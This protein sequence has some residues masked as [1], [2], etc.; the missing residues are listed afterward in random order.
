MEGLECVDLPVEAGAERKQ[1]L[2]VKHL[3]DNLSMACIKSLFGQFGASDV[4]RGRQSYFVEFKDD[5]AASFAQK[6]LHRVRLL[7]KLLAVE[8]VKQ[9]QGNATTP[10]PARGGGGD[11]TGP[12]LRPTGGQ[13]APADAP[14]QPPLAGTPGASGASLA[15][16]VPPPAVGALPQ[17]QSLQSNG[18]RQ[19]YSTGVVK[20]RGEAIAPSLG[21]DYP[22][23]PHLQYSYPPPDGNILAN[24]MNALIAVPR[25]YTQV[26]PSASQQP[27]SSQ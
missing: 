25:L 12:V 11:Q 20:P 7:G 5:A 22:F 18:G 3:P 27:V 4:R 6:Q 14:R 26:R 17:N 2:I 19:N 13:T 9:P 16:P 8:F 23:P 1:V 24:I 10:T 21:V 15:P